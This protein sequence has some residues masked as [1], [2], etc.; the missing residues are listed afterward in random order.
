MRIFLM[1]VKLEAGHEV[2]VNGRRLE[3]GDAEID[4]K[5]IGRQLNLEQQWQLICVLKKNINKLYSAY[6]AKRVAEGEVTEEELVRSERHRSR[7]R[8]HNPRL[9]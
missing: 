1:D 4:E 6:R 3:D 9:L 7:N 8:T 2:T 5:V